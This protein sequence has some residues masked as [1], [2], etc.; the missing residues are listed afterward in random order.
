M[1]T[2][3]ITGKVRLS[4]PHLFTPK[5]ANENAEPKYSA[6]LIIPKSDTKTLEKIEKAIET[7]KQEGIGKF[8]GKIP[9]VLKEPL[10][11]GDAERP[12]D[13]AY[14]DSYFLNASSKNAPGVI[15]Q[16]KRK[17][18]SD[19]DIYAGCYVRASLNFYAFNASGNRGIAVGLN[20]VQK[21]ADGERLSGGASADEDFDVIEIE[22]DDL[23][24]LV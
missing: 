22:E 5:A 17:L 13:P 21:W 3:V 23:G 7:A 24:D 18:T 11:D 9:A 2:K 12:D 14:A 1:S 20:N 15:D 19:D 6:S 8:G 4:Y 16:S 10:R